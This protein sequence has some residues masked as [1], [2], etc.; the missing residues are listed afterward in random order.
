MRNFFENTIVILLISVVIVYG[1]SVGIV[2]LCMKND[3]KNCI[4][5]GGKY[6]FEWSY[7]SKCH[8][9]KEWR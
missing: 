7:G 1:I 9:P 6:I 2:Y 5:N 4:K 8:L 3:E